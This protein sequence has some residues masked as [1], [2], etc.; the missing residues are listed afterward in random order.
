MIDPT[1]VEKVRKIPI[2]PSHYVLLVSYFDIAHI[3]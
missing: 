3:W 2:S 1:A